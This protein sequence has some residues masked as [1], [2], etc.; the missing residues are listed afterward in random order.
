MLKT[1]Q[2]NRGDSCPYNHKDAL[3]EY[4]KGKGK[5]AD[6]KG[7]GNGGFYGYQNYQQKGWNP[8]GFGKGGKDGRGKGKGIKGDCWNC[9]KPG[10]RSNDCWAAI[11][12]VSVETAAQ[13]VEVGGIFELACIEK[14]CQKSCCSGSKNDIVWEE[15][16]NMVGAFFVS[17]FLSCFIRAPLQDNSRP[18]NLL[19]SLKTKHARTA[20]PRCPKLG[21]WR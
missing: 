2:C 10:H 3:K 8:K 20:E 9:G 11:K 13:S 14:S 16:Q 12:E 6:S 19:P 5:G 17:V 15:I 4:K 18:E 1:G 21:G 7:K